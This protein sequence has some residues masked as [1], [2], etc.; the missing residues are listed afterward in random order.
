MKTTKRAGRMTVHAAC[1]V[2]LFVL[3]A[4]NGESL[5]I[6]RT[7]TENVTM[8]ALFSLSSCSLLTTT[9]VQ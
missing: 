6:E 9:T 8:P 1:F 4:V 3:V 5:L 2:A 7:C